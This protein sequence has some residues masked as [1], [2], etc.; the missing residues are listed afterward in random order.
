[1]FRFHINNYFCLHEE[2]TS[3]EK[4]GLKSMHEKKIM[5]R[6]E[7]NILIKQRETKHGLK[8]TIMQKDATFF[9]HFNVP[10]LY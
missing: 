6:E 1:M 4:L 9:H 3:I 7:K 5:L 2:I 8:V 10:H